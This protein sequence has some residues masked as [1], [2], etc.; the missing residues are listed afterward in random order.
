MKVN[1]NLTIDYEIYLNAKKNIENL[2][3]EVNNYLRRRLDLLDDEEKEATEEELKTLK[4]THLAS[5]QKLDKQIKKIEKKKKAE[6]DRVLFEM[7]L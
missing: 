1:I 6:E 4:D 7:E 3:G 5:V 2:S